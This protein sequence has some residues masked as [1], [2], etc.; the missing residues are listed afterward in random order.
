MVEMAGDSVN[1]DLGTILRSQVFRTPRMSGV[2][3]VALGLVAF[4]A[5]AALGGGWGLM[6]PAPDGSGLGMSV[7]WLEGSPFTSYVIPGLILFGVFGVGSLVTVVA[8]LLRSSVAPY[9]AFALGVG[10]MI[11]IVVETVI[12]SKAGF[13]PLQP[14]CFTL[15]VTIALLAFIWWRQV[16]LPALKLGR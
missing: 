15:G 7:S 8:G 5:V 16:C 4:L 9:F 3:L 13:H 2:G 12:M 1:P 6:N 14:F 10:Q 11:W